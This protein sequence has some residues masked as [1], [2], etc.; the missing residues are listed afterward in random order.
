M[1]RAILLYQPR[2]QFLY[3]DLRKGPGNEIVIV[4]VERAD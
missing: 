1:K 3:P 4:Y 2:S